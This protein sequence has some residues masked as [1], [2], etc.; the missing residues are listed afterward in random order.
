MVTINPLAVPKGQVFNCALSGEP[1]RIICPECRLVYYK[2]PEERELDWIGIH[3]RICKIIVSLNETKA[4][5][6]SEEEREKTAE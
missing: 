1:A 3:H 6:P 4:M 5:F 2:G